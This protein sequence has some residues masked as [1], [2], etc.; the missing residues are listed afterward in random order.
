MLALLHLSSGCS[1]FYIRVTY[2]NARRSQPKHNTYHYH[3]L[4]N[5][6][7]PL[8]QASASR[9]ATTVY[10]RRGDSSRRMPMYAPI[11][12]T[13]AMAA[14]AAAAIHPLSVMTPAPCACKSQPG[15]QR[16][17][18]ARELALTSSLA[19]PRQT[20]G[21]DT[22]TNAAHAQ[23]TLTPPPERR[24]P[25][26]AKAPTDGGLAWGTR[27]SAV[28]MCKG[29][30]G[31]AATPTSGST[32]RALTSAALAA[33]AA[34]A[35]ACSSATL[36]CTARCAVPAVSSDLASYCVPEN[37]NVSRFQQQECVKPDRRPLGWLLTSRTK[38]H[39]TQ[40]LVLSTGTARH[41]TVAL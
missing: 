9:E 33:T 15:H 5:R 22:A 39:D 28:Q 41:L 7:L 1:A 6:A 31:C 16:Q 20:E 10:G 8:H 25:A 14:S 32:I 26:P 19:L 37:P 38:V 36:A 23:E 30:R 3:K 40:C 2:R 13:I 11:T 4:M 24:W 29:Y 34:R 21:F 18:P 27:N 35:L 17:V 12:A